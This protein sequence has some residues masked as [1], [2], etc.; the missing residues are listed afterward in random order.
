MTKARTIPYPGRCR[1]PLADATRPAGHP[2]WNK[3]VPPVGSTRVLD[4]GGHLVG[5][6][7]SP[8]DPTGQR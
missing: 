7:C 3:P 5:F 1:D 8:T 4:A 2:D 6:R